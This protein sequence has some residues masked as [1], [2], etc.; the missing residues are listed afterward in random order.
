MR[1]VLASITLSLLLAPALALASTDQEAG[2]VD[3][4][5]APQIEIQTAPPDDSAWI[6]SKKIRRM[7]RRSSEQ[8]AVAVPEP[9]AAL[10]FGAGVMIAAARLRRRRDA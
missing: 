5:S 9:S 6:M 7:N 4:T 2:Q 3:E 1:I 10:V 8:P